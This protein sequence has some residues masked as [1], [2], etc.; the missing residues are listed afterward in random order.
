MYCR[1]KKRQ[2][3]GPLECLVEFMG[4]SAKGLREVRIFSA[5]TITFQS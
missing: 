1:F 2:K 5:T 4:K 3:V